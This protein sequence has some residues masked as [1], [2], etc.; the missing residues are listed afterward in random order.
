MGNLL[1]TCVKVRQTIE[2]SFGVMSGVGPG[3]GVLD[4]SSR[5]MEGRESFGVVLPICLNGVFE[6]IF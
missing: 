6:C 5:A 1:R 3:I 4:G 2:L